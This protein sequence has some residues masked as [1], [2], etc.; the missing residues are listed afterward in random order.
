M[1]RN[2]KYRVENKEHGIA[3][4]IAM[5]VITMLTGIGIM[6]LNASRFEIRSTGYM[7][8][9]TQAEYLAESGLNLGIQVFSQSYDAYVRLQQKHGTSKVADIRMQDLVD[10]GIQ[11]LAPSTD[12]N[13]GS[14]GWT[15][16]EPHFQVIADRPVESVGVSGYS[17]PGSNSPHFCFK[18]FRFTG[19]GRLVYNDDPLQYSTSQR[20]Y[21]AFVKI[22]PVECSQ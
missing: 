8:Q 6:A 19:R 10:S 12:E 13:P 14:L 9:A 2:V 20:S 3:M 21:R 5:L 11:V 16:A 4:V 17:L 15:K 1:L 18:R 22:G 7:R